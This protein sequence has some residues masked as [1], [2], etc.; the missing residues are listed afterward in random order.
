MSYNNYVCFVKQGHIF[1]N[2]FC[3]PSRTLASARYHAESIAQSLYPE[4]EYEIEVKQVR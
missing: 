2:S 3:L 1:I 4:L